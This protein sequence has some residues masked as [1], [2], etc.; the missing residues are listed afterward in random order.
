MIRLYTGGALPPPDTEA[1]LRI[2]GLLAAYGSEC[3]FIRVWRTENGSLLS[4]L[5]GAAVLDLRAG[6]DR[7]EAFCFLSMQPEIRS[8][9][10]DADTARALAAFPA[11]SPS[12]APRLETGAVMRL[13]EALPPTAGMAVPVTPREVYALLALCFDGALP[14]F[15]SWYVDVSHRIRHGVCHLAAVVREETPAASA[16]TVA[17]YGGAALLGAVATHPR[18]RGRGYATACLAAL[19]E[20]LPDKRLSISPKNEKARGLYAHLGFVPCG[21]WGT[22]Y[23]D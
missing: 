2:G 19:A 1:A 3:P 11:F 7:E 18:F 15:D 8:V 23:K 17:E 12:A 10:T 5:D 21:E 22:V 4:L 13:A 20:V 14:P 6:E 16:M 9:R